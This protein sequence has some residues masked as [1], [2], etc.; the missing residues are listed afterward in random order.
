MDLFATVSRLPFSVLGP[1]RSD[2]CTV[3]RLNYKY[4]VIILVIFSIIVSNKQFSSDHIACWVPG[5]FT[6]SYEVYSNNI[7][8]VSNTYYVATAET[9]P[10]DE[11]KKKT[12]VVKYYQWTP[13]IL[14]FQAVLFYLPRMLWRSLSAK[15][16]INIVNLVDAA[17]NYQTADR[18][19]DRNKIM[20]YL[21]RSIDQYVYMRKRKRKRFDFIRRFLAFILCVPGRRMG[22][23]L[24]ILFFVTKLLFIVNSLGQLFLL[25]IFLGHNFASYGVDLIRKILNGEELTESIYFPRVTMCEFAVRNIQNVHVHTVQCV[26]PINLFNEKAFLFIWFWLAFLTI[27]NTYDLLAWFVRSFGRVRYAYIKKRLELMQSDTHL[28]RTPAKEFIHRYLQHDGVLILR[29]LAYNSSDLVV[30]ELIQQLWQFYKRAGS[31]AGGPA[32]TTGS[33]ISSSAIPPSSRA[34]PGGG[35]QVSVRLFESGVGGG[36]GR[37]DM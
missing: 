21:T 11:N 7:C 32:S 29:L 12:R 15:S 28:R 33:A 27:C 19:E 2:T 26:L 10:L 5:H 37:D 17:L 31:G 4:T 16:G 34:G 23:Y 1:H 14:L 35:R 36:A 20:T 6:R 24:L 13:F 8:W 22:S 3:D 25:N 9:L 30:T 18:F